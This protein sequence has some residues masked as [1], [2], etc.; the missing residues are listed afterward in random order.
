MY[1]AYFSSTSHKLEQ[2]TAPFSSCLSNKILQ[3]NDYTLAEYQHVPPLHCCETPLVKYEHMV[4]QS[5]L[6]TFHGSE[7]V[8]PPVSNPGGMKSFVGQPA[9]CYLGKGPWP[10]SLLTPRNPG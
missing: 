8:P 9:E 1:H 7:D 5:V 6:L 4:I 3:P 2:I 10:P